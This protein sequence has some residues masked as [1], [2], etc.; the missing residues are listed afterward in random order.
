MILC[1]HKLEMAKFSGLNLANPRFERDSHDR[2]TNLEHF[3]EDCRILFDGPLLDIKEKPKAGLIINWLGREAAQVL[4]SMDIEANSPDDVYET[5]E[6]VFR[7]ESNQTLARFKLRNMKQGATQYCDVYMSQ[8]RLALPKCKYKHDS[9]ELLKDQ[10]I[11]GIHNKEIQDH[12]LGELSEMDN[13]VLTLYEA[14][15]IESKLEQHKLLGIVTPSA[16]GVDAIR[17][18]R[19]S[20]GEKCDYCGQ[21]H[22][23]G[24]QNCPAYGKT[25][26]KCG[27]KN[28]FKEKGQTR[29]AKVHT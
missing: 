9:N 10:F 22:K 17:K 1:I 8:L 7:P 16:V 4:K 25:C 13:S 11:F 28:H 3:K 15:K 21:H 5:L 19:S 29:S 6:K 27:Q 12:L 23:K 18:N 24:K 20:Q 14:R 2:L 26:N